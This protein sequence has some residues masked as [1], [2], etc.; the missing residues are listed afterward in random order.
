MLLGDIEAGEG[1]G[2]GGAGGGGGESISSWPGAGCTRAV[3]DSLYSHMPAF[4][5]LGLVSWHHLVREDDNNGPRSTIGLDL[6]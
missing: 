4:G 2:C 1:R 6:E 5:S 3:L